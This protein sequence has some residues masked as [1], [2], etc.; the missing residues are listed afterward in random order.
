VTEADEIESGAAALGVALRSEQRDALVQFAALLRRWNNAFNL[1]SRRDIPRLGARHLLDAL[2]LAPML[3]GRRVLDL[4]TGAGLPGIALAIARPDVEFTLLDRS[5]RRI[6]FVR[7]AT[8]E[9]NLRN[10]APIACDYADFRAGTLFDTVVSRAVAKPA[11]LWRVA[12][13]LLAP[14]G[15][16]L[17]QVG[18]RERDAAD[19]DANVEPLLVRIPGL[20]QAHHLLR[21]SRSAATPN[22][23]P[24]DADR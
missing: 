7:Q 18:A 16:A 9:L 20:T 8:I 2:S 22:M 6:R 1:V 14:G 24:Q 4:G 11:V 23:A 3:H 19:L 5:E 17:F 13:N 15:I 10:A 12:A 21:V